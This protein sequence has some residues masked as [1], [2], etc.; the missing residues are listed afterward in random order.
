MSW[1]ECTKCGLVGLMT[2]LLS[3]LVGIGG[4]VLMVP[5]MVY[6]LHFNQHRAHGTSL[7]IMVPIALVGAASYAWSGNVNWILT[8]TL[9]PGGMLGAFAGARLTKRVP[10]PQLRA[11]FA[12][13]VLLISLRMMLGNGQGSYQEVQQL[14][15]AAAAAAGLVTGLVTGFLSGLLG[16][17]GGIVMVPTLALVIGVVQ[18]V[19]QGTSLAAIVPTAISGA[20]THYRMGNV[21]FSGALA[22]GL[23][24]MMGS[25]IGSRVANHLDAPTLKNVFGAILLLIALFMLYQTLRRMQANSAGAGDSGGK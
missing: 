2:G 20:R 13:F 1:A 10:G 21:D 14:G 15:Q 7:A 18:Q 3:G 11:I 17:G 22:I 8:A 9:V 5:A 16:I 25:F 6:F 19:A 23:G 4:G 24:G 12:G